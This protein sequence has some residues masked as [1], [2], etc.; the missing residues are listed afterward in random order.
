MWIPF[1]YHWICFTPKILFRL[2]FDLRHKL[3]LGIVHHSEQL[4]HW[5]KQWYINSI[6]T[7]PPAVIIR[8][9]LGFLSDTS[10]KAFAQFYLSLS[11]TIQLFETWEDWPL[12][13]KKRHSCWNLICLW[14][15]LFAFFLKNTICI[16][17]E[18]SWWYKSALGWEMHWILLN[19]KP[20]SLASFSNPGQDSKHDVY[21]N[22]YV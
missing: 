14:M 19:K 11:R 15:K 20:Y 12:I 5:S 10:E 2:L 1:Q 13:L 8:V 4:N 9:W 3:S 6:Y 7:N 18:P 21:V 16:S 22:A 17:L